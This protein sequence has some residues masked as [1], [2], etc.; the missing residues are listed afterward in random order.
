M[1]HLSRRGLP[2]AA[3]ALLLASTACDD[4]PSGPQVWTRDAVG[5]RWVAI[6]EPVGMPSARSWAPW[7]PALTQDSAR[8]L[9]LAAARERRSGRIEVALAAEQEAAELA[10]AGLARTPAATAVLSPLAA[11]A[12]SG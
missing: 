10:A 7:D 8:G 6:A 11:L 4:L 3:L 9:L 5:R 12:S 2:A 1:P